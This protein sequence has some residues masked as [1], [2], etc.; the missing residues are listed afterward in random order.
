M[1]F[2]EGRKGQRR[3]SAKLLQHVPGLGASQINVSAEAD[4]NNSFN[5]QDVIVRSVLTGPIE[6]RLQFD[7]RKAR[8]ARRQRRF[9]RR[10]ACTLP[11]ISF[12]HAN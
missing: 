12:T 6:K 9:P 7:W 2:V 4:N 10:A 1:N 3:I 8:E 5:F 11:M